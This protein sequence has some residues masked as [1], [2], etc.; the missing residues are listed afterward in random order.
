MITPTK[1]FTTSDG[2]VWNKIEEA[3]EREIRI[4]VLPDNLKSSKEI[5]EAIHLIV[6]QKDAIVDI[7][8]MT[9]TSKPS[10]R[11]IHGGTKKRKA[12]TEPQP[13]TPVPA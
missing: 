7:L 10:A 3:M 13:V 4:A 1:A 5:E 6:A 11:A 8:T 12:R 9:P 2:A